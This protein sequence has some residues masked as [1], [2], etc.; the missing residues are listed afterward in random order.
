M[1]APAPSVALIPVANKTLPKAPPKPEKPLSAYMRFS[2]KMYSVVKAEHPE[3]KMFEFGSIIG[4]RWK[5]L[6]PSEKREYHDAWE[7]DMVQY[8]AAIAAYRQSAEYKD[9]L[10]AVGA[11]Q[12]P[13]KSPAANIVEN[14]NFSMEHIKS[15]LKTKLAGETEYDDDPDDPD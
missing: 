1:P 14:V 5:R 13:P 3:L 15:E 7:A 11:E 8:N 9:W 6:R 4:Q 12:V 2:K 10:K